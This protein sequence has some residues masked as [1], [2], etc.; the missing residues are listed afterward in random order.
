[1]KTFLV[2]DRG[3]K[4]EYA[5][6]LRAHQSRIPT[7]T[8][9]VFD[10]WA[11]V[12]A[13]LDE[14]GLPQLILLDM[15]FDDGP[16]ENLAGD[17]HALA[18]STRFAGDAS[19]AEVQLRRLQGVFLLQA[20]REEAGYSG[21]VVL[22]GTLPRGQAQRLLKR[23]APLKILEGLLFEGVREALEWASSI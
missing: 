4:G 5:H 17:L 1:M 18:N 3:I 7:L 21:P 8:L 22:F 11:A 19:R 16:V 20:L 10:S 12:K 13:R 2:D 15:R 6:F 9:S 14:D 23:Y